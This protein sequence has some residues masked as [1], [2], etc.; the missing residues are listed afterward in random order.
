MSDDNIIHFNPWRDF[1]DA[2]PLADPFAVEPDADQIARFVDV[3]F[4]YSDGLI[5][6]RSFVDKERCDEAGEP[7]LAWIAAPLARLGQ[8]PAPERRDDE[9][10]NDQRHGQ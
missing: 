7:P 4:G 10:R 2:A 8:E 5:P 6:V 9:H 3:V 1:N